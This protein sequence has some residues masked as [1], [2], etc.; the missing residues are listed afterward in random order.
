M[1][2]NIS[3]LQNILEKGVVELLFSIKCM[4]K[5]NNTI[6]SQFK[7]NTNFE[8]WTLEIITKSKIYIFI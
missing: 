1:H 7:Q 4:Y 2:E 5:N 6:S 8:M 3:T